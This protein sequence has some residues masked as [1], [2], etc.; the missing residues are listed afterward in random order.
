MELD[1]SDNPLTEDAAE[2]LSN[3]IKHHACLKVLNLNDT[4]LG[5]AGASVVASS[6]AKSA[7]NL[8]VFFMGPC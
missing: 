7:P 1:L 5:D 4:C 6:L 8:E 2:G 3:V